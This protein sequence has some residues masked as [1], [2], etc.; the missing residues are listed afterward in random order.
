MRP[1]IIFL[2]IDVSHHRWVLCRLIS[3]LLVKQ[4][5][6]L[7]LVGYLLS[8]GSK[9]LLVL[10]LCLLQILNVDVQVW[11]FAS[12]DAHG[13]PVRVLSA[14]RLIL[15]ILKPPTVLLVQRLLLSIV[16]ERES[17]LGILISVSLAYPI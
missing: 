4:I 10:H 17:E 12:V 6:G 16:I 11:I 14:P 5:L 13:L 1:W 15:L 7:L 8:V 3:I 9:S 2:L